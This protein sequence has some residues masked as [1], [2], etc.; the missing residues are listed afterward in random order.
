MIKTIR[1]ATL[2]LL[3]TLLTT[4]AATRA[5][6]ASDEGPWLEYKHLSHVALPRYEPVKTQRGETLYAA[7]TALVD[8]IGFADVVPTEGGGAPTVTLTNAAGR[9]LLRFTKDHVG[10]MIGIFLD[11]AMIHGPMHIGEKFESIF[12]PDDLSSVDCMRLVEAWAAPV[13]TRKG[14]REIRIAGLGIITVE[15][16]HQSGD[17]VVFLHAG[18]LYRIPITFLSRPALPEPDTEALRVVITREGIRQDGLDLGTP[19]DAL[20]YIQKTANEKRF[21]MLD[22]SMEEMEQIP[23]DEMKALTPLFV[24]AD[25]SGSFVGLRQEMPK[26]W[27]W[28]AKEE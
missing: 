7:E 12:L 17:A 22:C 24:Y 2:L 8:P 5:V 4:V 14:K 9:R 15:I 27:K 20:R 23:E 19:V 3:T 10:E 21:I 11:G 28:S 18:S 6:G 13:N 16:R 26:D 25:D 1:W